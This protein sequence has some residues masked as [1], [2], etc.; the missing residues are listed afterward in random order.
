MKFILASQSPRRIEILKKADFKFKAIA[1]KIDESI[2]S[3]NLDPEDYCME[4]AKL[5]SKAI[6]K[7]Y[8]DYTVIGA[9]TIVFINGK[10]LNKPLNFS[11]AKK[12]LNLLSG[13]THKVLTGVSLQNQKLNINLSFFDVS[14]VTFYDIS[15]LEINHY[16]SNYNPLDKAGSYG[17]QDGSA[18]FVEKIYGSY[19]NIM[20][21][22][23]GRFYQSLKLI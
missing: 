16:I 11:E 15:D 6:S 12:M 19:E 5:K 1:S 4:L 2:I 3:T 18:I 14:E 8:P 13:N 20:G 22:P 23:I 7:K 21:F 10:I 17:I 9:D